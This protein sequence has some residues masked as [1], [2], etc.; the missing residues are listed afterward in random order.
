MAVRNFNETGGQ[1]GLPFESLTGTRDT[2][3]NALSTTLGGAGSRSPAGLAV[4]HRAMG[5]LLGAG[6]GL[7]G[8]DEIP[9]DPGLTAL[10][11]RQGAVRGSLELASTVARTIGKL[12]PDG[13]AIY[14]K[15]RSTFGTKVLRPYMDTLRK[16]GEVNG[17]ELA[18]RAAATIIVDLVS[19]P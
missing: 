13:V 19:L 5:Y 12:S 4:Q 14:R 16:Q 18:G 9:K 11:R 1:R 6:F 10:T 7:R 17:P 15:T 8:V 3:R 2:A